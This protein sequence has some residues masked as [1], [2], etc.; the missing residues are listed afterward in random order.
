MR[1]ITAIVC[2]FLFLAGFACGAWSF[3]GTQS[4]PLPPLRRCTAADQCLSDPQ[5]LGL[6]TSAGLHLAPGLMPDIVARNPECVGIRSPRP[7]ARIDLVFFP[8]RDIK[9][10]LDLAPG[11]QRYLLGCLALMRE[12]VQQQGL[13]NW[14]VYTNGAGVQEIAYLHLHLIVVE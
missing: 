3:V 8:V 2:I 9:D 11:D 14:R 1:S 13:H 10:L 5:V 4:R 6:L 12:V 7:E